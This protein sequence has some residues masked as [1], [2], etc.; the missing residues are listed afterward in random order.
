[1]DSVSMWWD[2]L[3][4]WAA[5]VYQMAVSVITAGHFKS[6]TWATAV[7]QLFDSTTYRNMIM[8]LQSVL[9]WPSVKM[10]PKHGVQFGGSW[11][12][13]NTN[14]HSA[15][16]ESLHIYTPKKW[17]WLQS[18]FQLYKSWYMHNVFLLK[19]GTYKIIVIVNI[20][21]GCL[22]KLLFQQRKFTQNHSIW[23]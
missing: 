12:F 7:L 11:W 3:A 5:H 14:I 9:H 15:L 2:S 8:H 10:S 20:V 21:I 17:Q 13:K 16:R 23:E 19:I 1:M 18:C 4:S 22:S 6:N